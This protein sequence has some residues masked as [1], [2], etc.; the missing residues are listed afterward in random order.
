MH[1]IKQMASLLSAAALAAALPLIPA[2][3]ADGEYDGKSSDGNFGYTLLDDGS[4]SV[5]CIN[6]QLEKAVVPSEIDGHAVTALTDGCFA[7]STHITEVTLPEGLTVIG[8]GAFNACE[9][10]TQAK[11]P[12]TVTTIGENAFYGCSG[13]TEIT[14][15]AAVTEI[16]SYA[17]DTTEGMTAFHVAQGNTAYSSQDGVL[18]DKN[19]VN[20]IKYPEAKSDAEY[21]VPDTCRSIADW[22]FIGAQYLEEID[23][24]KV[25]AIG[26]DAF[27][28]CVKLRSVKIPEGVKEL[29]GAAFCYC[30]ALEEVKLP[31]TL[32]SVGEN[33]FYSCT[34]LKKVV[35]PEGLKRIDSYAFFHCTSLASINIPKSVETISSFCIGY[36][37][38]EATEGK[39]P[40]KDLTV[41][42][43]KRTPG[44]TYASS[45][46]LTLKIV[47]GISLYHVLLGVAIA[48]IAVL[49]AAIVIILKKRRQ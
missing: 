15:P 47:S 19:A 12:E 34:S 44:Y 14:I 27:Y 20:L 30:I 31:S 3:A 25:N 38:D 32:E 17:F 40:Q 6:S 45:N 9:K 4:I 39:A 5:S 43:V 1:F 8:D 49:A 33:C 42:V 21:A 10:L 22:A 23:L 11:L 28:Y 13:L 35:L 24:G 16:Q 26:E 7:K 41:S 29:V 46:D 48:A 37:Y 18:F 36:R 2:A